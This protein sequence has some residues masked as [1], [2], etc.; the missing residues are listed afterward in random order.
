[1]KCRE[2]G[3]PLS[4]TEA[5]CG[6]S[7]SVAFNNRKRVTAQLSCREC[8]SPC[9]SA[10]AKRGRRFCSSC[11]A[12][13]KHRVRSH[14]FSLLKS[15]GSRRR[16]LLREVGRK[17]EVCFLTEWRGQSMPVVM[18]HKNGNSSDN[19]RENL[20]LICPN[21]DTQQPTFGAR[22]RGNGRHARRVRYAEGK[23]S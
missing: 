2:C 15:D 5:F 23:S 22:N 21:C 1:L 16:W 13:G 12:L 11:I 3:S 17:C 14:D 20:R 10:R 9:G 6:R 4:H 7:C 18:D 8:G 19:R